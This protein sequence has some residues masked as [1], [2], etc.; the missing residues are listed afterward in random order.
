VLPTSGQADN[1]FAGV[2][3]ESGNYGN[4]NVTGSTVVFRDEEGWKFDLQACN[5]PDSVKSKLW[6][7]AGET[8]IYIYTS[9]EDKWVSGHVAWYGMYESDLVKIIY[10]LLKQDPAASFL[11]LGSNIGVFTLTMALMGRPVVAVDPLYSNVQRLCMSVRAGGFRNV[12]I[13]RNPISNVREMVSLGTHKGNVGG[14]YVKASNISDKHR[15]N[16]GVISDK[17]RANGGVINVHTI[18][19]DDLMEIFPFQRLIVKI[20][21][22]TFEDEI[23]TGAVKFFDI[24]DVRYILMEWIAHKKDGQQIIDVLTKYNMDPLHSTTKAKLDVA[25]FGSSWPG[26]VLWKKR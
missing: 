4:A 11:D 25:K 14:T 26:N 6:S 2:K 12:T 8:P 22:E 3:T 19:I 24:V 21:V 20:D 16:E 9:A 7:P 23:I 15:A 18:L 10:D 13:V 1:P 5:A 17:N